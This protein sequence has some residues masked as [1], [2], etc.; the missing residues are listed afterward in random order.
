MTVSKS[1]GSMAKSERSVNTAEP[2]TGRP[3]KLSGNGDK[4][5]VLLVHGIRTRAEWQGPIRRKLEAKGLIV[6]LQRSKVRL[7]MS[8]SPSGLSPNKNIFPAW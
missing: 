8:S 3:L 1:V 7:K 5:I 4:H 2:A 6:K